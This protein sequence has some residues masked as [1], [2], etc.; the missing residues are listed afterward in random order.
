MLDPEGD[1]IMHRCILAMAVGVECQVCFCKIAVVRPVVLLE[2]CAAAGVEL[3]RGERT[4][5]RQQG[6]QRGPVMP[7]Q[8]RQVN[9]VDVPADPS[10]PC[11]AM[12][13]IYAV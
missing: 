2:G 9:Q 5:G 6:L 7:F 4:V 11:R 13:R 1:N 3:D 8:T 10:G 12:R